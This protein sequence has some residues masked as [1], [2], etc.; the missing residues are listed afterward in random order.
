MTYRHTE[1]GRS[2]LIY[3]SQPDTSWEQIWYEPKSTIREKVIMDN[4]ISFVNQRLGVWLTLDLQYILLDH[5]QYTFH[6]NSEMRDFDGVERI[7]YQGMSQ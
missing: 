6:G 3:D 7:W 4:R 2:G 5:Y 1:R